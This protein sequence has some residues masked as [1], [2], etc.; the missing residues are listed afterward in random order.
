MEVTVS[1]VNTNTGN[2]VVQSSQQSVDVPSINHRRNEARGTDKE[3]KR[4]R[5][6]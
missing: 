3:K 6:K 2:S 5:E 1:V 4:K